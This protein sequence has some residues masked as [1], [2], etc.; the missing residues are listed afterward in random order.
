MRTFDLYTTPTCGYCR[1][2][3]GVLQDRGISYLN[4]DVT[5][6]EQDLEEMQQLTGG[7]TS[8]P[9]L[10]VNKGR[11]DQRVAQGLDDAQWLLDDA[12]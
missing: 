8:V 2:L 11:E 3:K 9:V 6:S 12:K 4:H 1:Q 10:V 5:L 7:G